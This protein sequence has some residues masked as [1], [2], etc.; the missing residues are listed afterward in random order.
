MLFQLHLFEETGGKFQVEGLK[1]VLEVELKLEFKPESESILNPL[2]LIFVAR[3]VFAAAGN[4]FQGRGR[5]V[6]PRAQWKLGRV[7]GKERGCT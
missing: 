2:M 5:L 4:K 6:A 3:A 1:I 7:T